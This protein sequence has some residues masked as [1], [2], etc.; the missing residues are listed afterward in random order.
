M[1]DQGRR[2]DEL[3]IVKVC[4]G[5]YQGFGYI[6]KEASEEIDLLNENIRPYADNKDIQVIIKGYLRKYPEVKTIR[7]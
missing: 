7:F 4:N 5:S 2:D 1:I 3:A 6:S